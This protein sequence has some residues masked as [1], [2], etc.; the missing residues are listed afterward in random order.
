MPGFH[1]PL[2]SVLS[3]LSN[4]S[5]CDISHDGMASHGRDQSEAL[6]YEER[7]QKVIQSLI[8]KGEKHMPDNGEYY[9]IH[10]EFW[11]KA[12]YYGEPQQDIEDWLRKIKDFYKDQISSDALPDDGY[13]PPTQVELGNNSDKR[14]EELGPGGS[15]HQGPLQA[16]EYVH[17]TTSP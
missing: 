10:K 16:S 15:V 12:D 9:E 3:R 14:P 6:A 2:P 13:N 1:P 11:G 8:K 7:A 17:L 5:V 4:A